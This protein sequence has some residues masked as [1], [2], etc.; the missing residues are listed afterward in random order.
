[1]IFVFASA[2]Y[3][4][5]PHVWPVHMMHVTEA[6][7]VALAMISLVAALF[8]ATVPGQ[9]LLK[10]FVAL[11]GGVSASIGLIMPFELAPFFFHERGEVMMAS[12]LLILLYPPAA[13]AFWALLRKVM[14]NPR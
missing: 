13:L 2:G 8:L 7:L 6:V 12:I 1:M 11:V 14:Q 3:K 9:S 4:S 5:E 10:E